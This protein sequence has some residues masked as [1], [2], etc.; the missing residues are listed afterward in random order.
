MGFQGL[1]VDLEVRRQLKYD[2]NG[3]SKHKMGK[4]K[5]RFTQS[6][7]RKFDSH[8]DVITEG[9]RVNGLN[10]LLEVM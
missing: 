1:E 3:L 5:G 7:L 8:L 2:K 6:Y 9:D 4:L 10:K